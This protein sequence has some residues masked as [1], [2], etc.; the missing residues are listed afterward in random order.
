[1]WIERRRRLWYALHDIPADVQA[2]LSYGR[3]FVASLKT[4]DR[5]DALRRKATL[6]MKIR[7]EIAAAR[8]TTSDPIE[9]DAAFWRSR[10]DEA[11]SHQERELI[12]DFVADEAQERLEKLARINGMQDMTE[13]PDDPEISRFYKMATGQM[14]KLTE[15]LDEW[16][17]TL[18]NIQRTKDQKRSCIV[19]FAEKYPFIQDVS[20]KVVQQWANALAQDE[21]R[22]P[23]TITKNLSELRGYWDYLISLE[24]L[25]D[26]LR[27]FD[28]VKVLKV[29]KKAPEHQRK[30]FTPEQV[31]G[32]VAK[33]QE[34]GNQKL[35]DLIRLAMW[36]G[37]RIEELCSLKISRVHR[38]WFEIVDAKTDAGIRKVPIHSKLKPIM[39]RL[40]KTSSDGYVISG[41]SPNKY[42]D[43]SPAIGHSFGRLKGEMGFGEAHVFHSIRK[44][45]VTILENALVPEP[46]TMDIVGH[47]KP[48][49]TYGT[50]S[51][52]T[53]LEVMRTHLEKLRYPSPTTVAK[54]KKPAS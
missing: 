18:D 24:V 2:K 3:R 51:G 23:D 10:L 5:N 20:R 22:R 30:P 49:I 8:N 43:R 19:K 31:V 29:A 54:Q 9:A 16:L 38:G 14:I 46:I 36:T 35:A 28:K 21:G 37:A 47:E 39:D 32:L 41:L 12:L 15:K 27:P 26:D 50:Y 44:T 52:G 53:S 33:A 17:D 42:G 1:M 4:E 11:A 25:P 40:T 34:K 48:S 7:R 6:E 13:L 45:V